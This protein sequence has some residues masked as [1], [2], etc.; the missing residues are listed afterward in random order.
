LQPF[1]LLAGR[2]YTGGLLQDAGIAGQLPGF[3]LESLAA[4]SE[5][6]G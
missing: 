1:C 5:G 3:S 2:G 6:G 4:V